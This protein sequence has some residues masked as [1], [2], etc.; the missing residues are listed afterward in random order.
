M[1]TWERSELCS[2][3]SRSDLILVE[4]HKAPPKRKRPQTVTQP[5]TRPT[6]RSLARVAEAN[7]D[8]GEEPN[9]DH[10]AVALHAEEAES[11]RAAA[12]EA[13]IAAATD[14]RWKLKHLPASGMH[15]H[16]VEVKYC[17]DTRPEPQLEAARQQHPN[18]I[19]NLECKRVTLHVILLVGAQ[20]THYSSL[21]ALGLDNHRALALAKT[22][23]IHSVK[24]TTKV[25]QTRRGLEFAGLA[26]N[27]PRDPH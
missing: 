23:H 26:A 9:I 15:V 14:T 19:A 20:G 17:D 25:I 2:R 1:A 8:E 18:L 5:R 21:Q 16:L 24:Y 3:S 22:L 7:D 11:K 13:A 27:N 6:T 12:N 4:P 10:A